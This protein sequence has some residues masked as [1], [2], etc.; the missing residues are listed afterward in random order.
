MAP[1][2]EKTIWTSNVLLPVDFLVA[3]GGSLEVNAGVTV[4]AEADK[5]VEI[6]VD[7]PLLALGQ[8]D[9][10]RVTFTSSNTDPG[11]WDGIRFIDGSDDTTTSSLEYVDIRYPE[12]GVQLDSLSG[13]LFHPTFEGVQT[14]EI[15]LDRDTRIPYGCEWNLDAPTRVVAE[16]DSDFYHAGEDT[17]RV[18]IVVNGALRTQSASPGYWVE[19]TSTAPDVFNGDDWHGLTIRGTGFNDGVGVGEIQNADIGYAI[20]PLAFWIA[21]TATVKNS[22]IQAYQEEGIVDWGSDALIESCT[23]VRGGDLLETYGLTGIHSIESESEISHNEVGWHNNYGVWGDFNSTLCGESIPPSPPRALK[24]VHN[25]ILGKGI[26]QGDFGRGLFLEWICHNWEAGVYGNFVN[27]WSM[28]GIRVHNCADVSLQCNCIAGNRIGL[29]FHRISSG[30]GHM[31]PGDG[32][33]YF[34]RNYFE[35]NQEVN[36]KVSEAA[37]SSLFLGINGNPATGQ[38]SFDEYVGGA[39]NMSIA[40]LWEVEIKAEQNAWRDSTGQV[41]S[42]S[43]SILDTISKGIAVVDVVPFLLAD[44]LCAGVNED[45]SLGS[46]ALMAMQGGLAPEGPEPDGGPHPT[47]GDSD[48][49]LPTFFALHPARPNPSSGGVMLEFD[50]PTG[51]SGHAELRIYDVAGR[52]VESLADGLFEPGRFKIRWNHTSSNGEP[53]ASG[54]YFARF[55]AEGFSKVR[56]VTILQ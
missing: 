43:Q 22:L 36:L 48:P 44:A 16:A 4:T 6:R 55:R 25:K 37:D 49:E 50:V 21:D 47:G 7:G 8:D 27:D 56:K 51:Y 3:P 29:K 13:T 33:V 9:N 54:I 12:F 52:L 34:R 24:I 26:S 14:H 18:E 31:P 45:C 42:D 40:T 30:S 2:W 35:Q 23:V 17:G 53:V 28:Q 20:N 5:D 1:P 38:N 11:S 46:S 41:L 19:F 39:W 10:N 15:Y 32:R